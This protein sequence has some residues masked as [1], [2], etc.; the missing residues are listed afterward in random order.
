MDDQ[1]VRE[2]R[3]MGRERSLIVLCDATR[4]QLL[5]LQ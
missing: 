2:W 1:M 5:N 4:E 3:M